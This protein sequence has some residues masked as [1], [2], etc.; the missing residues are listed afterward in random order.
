M[1]CTTKRLGFI[2]AV[3]VGLFATPSLCWAQY[4]IFVQIDGIPGESQD[5]QHKDWIDAFGFGDGL[6]G[7]SVAAMAGAV[8][9]RATFAD[10]KI[11]KGL[12]KAS[13]KLRES[14]ASGKHLKD[15]T[16]EFVLKSSVRP[17]KFKV[18]LEEVQISGVS[19]TTNTV[20][21]PQEIVTFSFGE[22]R[23]EYF[24]IDPET[25]VPVGQVSTGWNLLTNKPIQ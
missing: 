13:P 16:I 23:W 20:D 22:I 21:L 5:E 11:T 24:I 1:N 2:V 4:D 25:G 15:V 6:Q 18:T 9:G 17:L 14:A 8:A 19:L 7:S 10:I 12:D 3:L